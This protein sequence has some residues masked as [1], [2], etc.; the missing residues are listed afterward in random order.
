MPSIPLVQPRFSNHDVRFLNAA[1][2][3][4]AQILEKFI[5]AGVD[6]DDTDAN[7]NTALIFATMAGHLQIV[8]L[9]L[10]AG[11]DFRKKSNDGWDAYHCA[12]FFGDMKGMTMSPHKEIMSLL[13]TVGY[14]PE[15]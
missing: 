9:L 4:D 5:E 1:K 15:Q 2:S 8:N 12:M 14:D 3:G 13:S 6:L 11:A 10:D 7:G